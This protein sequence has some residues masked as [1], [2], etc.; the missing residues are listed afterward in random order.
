[1]IQTAT[2]FSDTIR[3]CSPMMANRTA[4]GNFRRLKECRM[5]SL[6]YWKRAFEPIPI[7]TKLL[8]KADTSDHL[9][10]SFREL[11][12]RFCKSVSTRR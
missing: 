7:R 6:Q 11:G 5:I 3:K 9:I 1:M 4:K 12:L 2:I 8:T 10:R